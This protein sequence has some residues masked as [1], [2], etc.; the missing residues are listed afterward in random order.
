MARQ[1][2]WYVCAQISKLLSAA[3]TTLCVCMQEMRESRCCIYL[4]PWFSSAHCRESGGSWHTCLAAYS[5]LA[6]C[7]SIRSIWSTMPRNISVMPEP[8]LRT[9]CCLRKLSY[10]TEPGST[11]GASRGTGKGL[12]KEE[13]TIVIDRNC[14]FGYY[15]SVVAT[16]PGHTCK[17]VQT[18]LRWLHATCN[19]YMYM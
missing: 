7:C 1:F 5:Y 15:G 8:E 3:T 2:S 12:T 13:S 9:L 4:V 14:W 6:S 19:M 16:P 18:I 10:C 11:R 17:Y